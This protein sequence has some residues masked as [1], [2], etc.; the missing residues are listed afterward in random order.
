MEIDYIN[1]PKINKIFGL[2][3]ANFNHKIPLS[4][5]ILS[6]YLGKSLWLLD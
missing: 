5:G 6:L 2:K 3:S 1:G 4:K